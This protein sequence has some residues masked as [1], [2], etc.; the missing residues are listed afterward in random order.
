MSTAPASLHKRQKRSCRTYSCLIRDATPPL[1]R[2]SPGQNRSSCFPAVGR[3]LA[4]FMSFL[5]LL[6]RFRETSS[7]PVVERA[8]PL[9]Q[10]EVPC[11]P[12][13]GPIL[14]PAKVAVSSDHPEAKA[15]RPSRKA[16]A[17]SLPDPRPS[18]EEGPHTSASPEG[19]D[20]VPSRLLSRK[21][22]GRPCSS[23]SEWPSCKEGPGP[24]CLCFSDKTLA[25]VAKATTPVSS[26]KVAQNS[27]LRGVQGLS[28]TLLPAS[29]VSV[30]N[31][32]GEVNP[33]RPRRRSVRRRVRTPASDA[34]SSFYPLAMQRSPRFQPAGPRP[35]FEK[36]MFVPAALLEGDQQ[37]RREI[38]GISIP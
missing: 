12:F 11:R 1:P 26:K 28:T 33:S 34:A 15:L 38:R 5:I 10:E 32:P 36:Q 3:G 4:Y 35:A 29:F 16:S 30:K 19:V 8:A 6:R 17:V 23:V 18:T 27:L 2:G 9:I 20:L 7:T 24:F 37:C 13:K 25:A 22:Y 31:V 21:D 14:P